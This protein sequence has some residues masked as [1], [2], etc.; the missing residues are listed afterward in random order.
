MLLSQEIDHINWEINQ[1]LAQIEA[2]TQHQN[3]L[4]QLEAIA[5]DIL[6]QMGNLAAKIKQHAPQALASFRSTI[7][8]LLNNE[9]DGKDKDFPPATSPDTNPTP[10]ADNCVTPESE[11]PNNQS[12][13]QPENSDTEIVQH[14]DN[15]ALACR[16]KQDGE[17]ISILI[18]CNNRIRLND[19][20]EWIYRNDW[21][22]TRQRGL[23]H[24]RRQTY[25]ISFA[26][27]L[28]FK[29]E[30]SLPALPSLVLDILATNDYS[31]P[32]IMPRPLNQNL[33]LIRG[34]KV[35]SHLDNGDF[36]VESQKTG[37]LNLMN[38]DD[39][40]AKL[41]VPAPIAA[42]KE[43][44]SEKPEHLIEAGILEQGEEDI[45]TSSMTP[46]TLAKLIREAWSW[47]EIEAVVAS[48]EQH[49]RAA[50][51]LLSKEEQNHVLV[52]KLQGEQGEPPSG[53]SAPKSVATTP[54]LSSDQT[55]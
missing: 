53:I 8:N 51:A 20:A 49:K 47:S 37:Q 9:D 21:G 13:S 15:P 40:Q 32:P 2:K 33:P 45:Q 39:N 16:Y 38:G 48:N 55:G 30:L 7:L 1:L 14:P 22:L 46:E 52:L 24:P 19:W 6:S 42:P 23:F 28:K 54:D 31:K 18:G 11:L 5:D 50:W 36:E 41:I 26:K 44:T 17:V 27:H 34:V 43:A 25:S 3:Q 12:S 35:E 10:V 4:I 29:Y